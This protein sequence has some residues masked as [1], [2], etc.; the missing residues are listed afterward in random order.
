[1]LFILGM[2]QPSGGAGGPLANPV[3]MIV[4]FVGIFYFL[5]IR[6]QQKKQKEL[7]K[8][9]T[10]LKKGDK[11]ITTGGIHG[12]IVNIKDNNVLSVKV[13]DDVKID[14]SRGNVAVVKKE[15][16]ETT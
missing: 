16:P 2:A 6:P 9:L 15:Q 10:E 13:A 14:I 7:Q 8:M 1:M 11:I 12:V 3:F 4:I 5:L